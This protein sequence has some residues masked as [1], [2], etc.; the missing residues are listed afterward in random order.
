MEGLDN[1]ADQALAPL[2]D[3]LEDLIG[4]LLDKED[5]LME[6][7]DDATSDSL[8]S[9]DK[10]IGWD[11]MDGPMASMS[12]KGVTGNRLPNTNEMGGRSGEGRSGKS[13]GQFVE[14][15]AFGKGGRQTPTRNT[16]TPFEAG[17]VKDHAPES[18][19]GATG[20]GKRS[21]AGQEGLEGQ[22]PPCRGEL[23]RM[24]NIQQNLITQ[25]K[26]LDRGLEKY[27]Y[28]RGDLPKTIELM[29][30]YESELDSLSKGES[31]PTAGKTNKAVLQ[32]LQE[33]KDLVAKQKEL[34]RDNTALMPKELRDEIASSQQEGVPREY[35]DMVDSY[36]RALSE[37]SNK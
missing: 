28:P 13:S 31:I 23:K 17:T 26:R 22:A 37:S 7:A 5:E 6:D 4:E 1:K 20:G 18:A 16:P 36:F 33:M 12:A 10:G 15:E 19:S 14:E 34:S 11:A 3:E 27:N 21:G 30:Q 32:N 25:A 24:A 29:E 35:Q 9:M 8:S 2:P